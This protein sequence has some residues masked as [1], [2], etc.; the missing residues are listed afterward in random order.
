MIFDLVQIEGDMLWTE[1]GQIAHPTKTRKDRDIPDPF[2]FPIRLQSRSF[3]G[4][5]RFAVTIL[6]QSRAF[7]VTGICDGN[8]CVKR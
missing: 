1:D 6:L 8:L 4:H 2:A 3:C 5:D 7:A